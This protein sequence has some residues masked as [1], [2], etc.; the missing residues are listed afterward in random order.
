MANR[1]KDSVIGFD[2]LAWMKETSHESSISSHEPTPTTDD[3]QPAMEVSNRPSTSATHD[4]RL[5]TDDLPSA[6]QLGDTLTI[7]HVSDM[8]ADLVRR[9]GAKVVV[10]EA[11]ALTRV[12]TAGLQL[13]AAFIRTAENHGTRVEWRAPQ[14]TLHEAA[15]RIGLDGALRL[16]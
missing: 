14:S 10:L 7:E 2:P 8:H 9:L 12:D 5:A 11:G 4:P 16:A 3:S 1:K 15:R 6:V 13:L